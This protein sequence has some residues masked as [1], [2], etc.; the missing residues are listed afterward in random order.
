MLSKVI[1]NY[2]RRF[3]VSS[4]NEELPAT[5]PLRKT[6]IY[7][8]FA[9]MGAVWGAQYGLEVVDYFSHAGEPSFENELFSPL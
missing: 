4:L 5:R 8:I 3:S 6:A 7:D 2:Q 1:E 9:S